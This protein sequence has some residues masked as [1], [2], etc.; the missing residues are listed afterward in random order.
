MNPKHDI[1]VHLG[2]DEADES[3]QAFID[4]KIEE[5]RA[6][7]ERINPH[8]PEDIVDEYVV[9][10]ILNDLTKDMNFTDGRFS[11][12]EQAEDVRRRLSHALLRLQGMRIWRPRDDGDE[13]D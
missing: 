13:E 8:A 6:R 2:L 4:R 11:I 5:Y 12:T 9:A 1:Y 3:L 10:M 7:A